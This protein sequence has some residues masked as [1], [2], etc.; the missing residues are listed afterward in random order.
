M[1]SRG[2]LMDSDKS[3]IEKL[4]VILVRTFASFVNIADNFDALGALYD[5]LT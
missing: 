1:M 2:I 5:L 4:S 3:K